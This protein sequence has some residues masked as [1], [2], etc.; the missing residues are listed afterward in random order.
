MHKYQHMDFWYDTPPGSLL[1]E[2]EARKLSKLLAR[3]PGEVLLQLG[4]PSDMALTRQG[5]EKFKVYYALTEHTTVGVPSITGQLEHI[6]LQPE[7]I[8]VIVLSHVLATADD[9]A[10]LFKDLYA[11]LRPSGTLIVLGFNRYSLWG[12]NALFQ[13]SAH[14]PWN[15]RFHSQ[16]MVKAWLRSAEFQIIVDQT[17]CFHAPTVNAKHWQERYFFEIAGQFLLP[18][19]GGVFMILAR[20]RGAGMTP[21]ASEWFS[22]ATDTIQVGQ[23]EPVARH[24]NERNYNEES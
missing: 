10:T 7:S 24:Y 13:R 6:P 15:A 23:A 11:A 18:G 4:G 12:I 19:C 21:L 20:K 3:T 2:Y 9:P 17:F 22:K 1:I 16:K 8:D 14:F 5:W